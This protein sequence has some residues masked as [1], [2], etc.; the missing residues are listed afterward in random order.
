ML[1]INKYPELVSAA[2]NPVEFSFTNTSYQVGDLFYLDVKTEAGTLITT[3]VKNGTGTGSAT[4]DISSVLQTLFTEVYIPS[5]N[6]KIQKDTSALKS[7]KVT[8]GVLEIEGNQQY[9]IPYFSTDTMYAL[10]AALPLDNSVKA[11][12]MVVDCLSE[13]DYLT[14]IASSQPQGSDLYLPV[15][16]LAEIDAYLVF[17]FGTTQELY[18]FSFPEAGVYLINVKPE[19]YG[20]SADNF[21][22]YLESDFNYYFSTQLGFSACAAGYYGSHRSIATGFSNIDQETAVT[23]AQTAANALALANKVCTLIPVE[24]SGGGDED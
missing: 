15:L 10:R 12:S 5:G 13:A 22:C 6:T 16:V 1:T 18:P 17:N 14:S 23:N 2:Y 24:G 7:Y 9:K 3:L 21:S 8:A 20:Y 11:G 4:F 19:L